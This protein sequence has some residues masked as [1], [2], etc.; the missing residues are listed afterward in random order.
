MRDVQVYGGTDVETIVRIDRGSAADWRERIAASVT[1]HPLGH[2]V[3]G[4][5]RPVRVESHAQIAEPAMLSRLNGKP[6]VML[7]VIRD[8]EVSLFRFDAALRERGIG[9]EVWSEAREL[10]ALLLRLAI[11]ALL[12]TLILAFRG[13]AMYVPL[14]IALAINVARVTDAHVDAYTLV[15]AAIAVLAYLVLTK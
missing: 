3:F 7:A 13:A 12:A 15:L 14:A 1:P 2:G 6:A 4:V 11:G 9:E 8:P 5:S 10:R